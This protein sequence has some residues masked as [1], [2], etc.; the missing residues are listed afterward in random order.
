MSPGPDLMSPV[1][2]AASWCE[3]W[4]VL[5][6]SFERPIRKL[7]PAAVEALHRLIDAFPPPALS[8]FAI[9][10]GDWIDFDARGLKAQVRKALIGRDKPI[11]GN[12]SVWE[13]QANIPDFIVDLHRLGARLAD[14]Q[15]F[16]RL[17]YGSRSPSANSFNVATP[18]CGSGE[19]WPNSLARLQRTSTSRLKATD[20]DYRLWRSVTAM[21]TFRTSIPW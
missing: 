5:P 14:L 21:S 4:F 3:R 17:P 6:S 19:S 13:A 1:A 7:A 18:R 12:A 8:L 20:A 11:N 15:E 9:P 2:Q 10:S 16:W